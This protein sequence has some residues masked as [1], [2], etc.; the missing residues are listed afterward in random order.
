LTPGYNNDILFIVYMA[1]PMMGRSIPCIFL[2]REGSLGWK[3]PKERGRR[4]PL[5]E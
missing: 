5:S 1:V 2:S 4:S 3:L